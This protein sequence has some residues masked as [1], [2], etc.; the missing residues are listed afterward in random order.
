M[1][2]PC[3]P[4]HSGSCHHTCELVFRFQWHTYVTQQLH[5][6][7]ESK[8]RRSSSSCLALWPV[9]PAAEAFRVTAVRQGEPPNSR[10]RL[11]TTLLTPPLVASPPATPEV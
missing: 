8:L 6:S 11:P 3:Q 2:G 7:C 5:Q 10:P 9:S 1:H 4:S